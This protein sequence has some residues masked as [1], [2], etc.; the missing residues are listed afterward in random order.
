M[1]TTGDPLALARAVTT[2]V[3]D[4][5]GVVAEVG[6]MEHFVENNT[7]R[8]DQA[9]GLLSIFAALALIL[10]ITGLNGVISLW[11]A[12]RTREIGIR[13][14]IGARRGNVIGLVLLESFR[15]VIVGLAIGLT[16]AVLMGRFVAALLYH[17]QP[18]DPMVLA[19]VAISTASA[20]LIACWFPLLRA[21]RV[22]PMIALRCD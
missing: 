6:T 13:M 3:R 1:R 4:L 9:A 20:A 10:S 16:A 7:W 18:A 21:M 2:V 22:D 19:A 8:Q 17:V 15:P 12:L 14:A 5:G 11:V